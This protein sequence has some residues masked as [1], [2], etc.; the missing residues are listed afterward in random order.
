[1]RAVLTWRICRR[2]HQKLDGE[3]AR[4][5]GGRWNSEGV[6]VVYSSSTLSLAALELVVHVD[7]ED[8]PDDL[9]AMAIEVPDDAGVDSVALAELPPD[10]NQVPDHPACVAIG[11]AWVRESVDL[12]LRVPSAVIPEEW[13]VLINPRHSRVGE[14]VVRSVRSFAFDA[15]VF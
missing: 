13:N 3:G 12:L 7:I 2:A 5:Y 6:A 10:W 9:V 8:V 15:R 14:L 1:V 11:D 4:L